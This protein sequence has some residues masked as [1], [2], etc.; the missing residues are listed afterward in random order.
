M[1]PNRPLLEVL[2]VSKQY[3]RAHSP[4]QILF[5]HAALTMRKLLG[6]RIER[7]PDENFAV[8]KVSFEAFAG[9]TVG[10]VGENGAG[11]STLV[12]MIY[13]ILKLIF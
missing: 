3:P 8:N 13:G 10:I 11:K 4:Q 6:L 2:S 1:T 9:E 7:S 12:K 5:Q